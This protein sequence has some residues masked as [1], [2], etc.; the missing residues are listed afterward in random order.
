MGKFFIPIFSSLLLVCSLDLAESQKK[1]NPKKLNL[2]ANWDWAIGDW[3]HCLVTDQMNFGGSA[4]SKHVNEDQACRGIH[5][6]NI[7]YSG[8]KNESILELTH[9]YLNHCEMWSMGG[10]L[11]PNATQ[12]GN[13]RGDEGNILVRTTAQGI[14]SHMPGKENKITFY[15]DHV[16]A[17]DSSGSWVKGAM[18]H[19]EDMD[20]FDCTL[21]NLKKAKGMICEVRQNEVRSSGWGDIDYSDYGSYFLVQDMTKCN[22]CDKKKPKP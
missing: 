14:G 12:V 5:F 8:G 21:L 20:W 17:M 10:P 7:H 15:G 19:V 18:A 1:K 4:Q 16:H 6:G 22:Y 2:K 11:C 3:Y 9:D 13:D